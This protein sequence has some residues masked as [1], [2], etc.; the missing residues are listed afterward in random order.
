MKMIPWISFMMM[1]AAYG[2]YLMVRMFIWALKDFTGPNPDTQQFLTIGGVTMVG[3][4]AAWVVLI[5]GALE[6]HRLIKQKRRKP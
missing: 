6:L 2:F 1:L 5:G 4:C 3:A